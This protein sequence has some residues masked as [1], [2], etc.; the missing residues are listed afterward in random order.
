MCP[1]S[2]P[3]P[4]R[5]M[6][7]CFSPV[8]FFISFLSVSTSLCVCPSLV[9]SLALSLHLPSHLSPHC[10]LSPCALPLFSS[11]CLCASLSISLRL[12][13]HSRL[14]SPSSAV[15]QCLFPQS[16]SVS[17]SP[18]CSLPFLR[19]LSKLAQPWPTGSS[20]AARPLLVPEK[21]RCQSLRQ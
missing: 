1:Q 11:L 4:R 6:P 21:F 9:F 19:S 15:S 10:V 20:V 2:L 17:T 8:L 16:S 18:G 3:R 13:V 5:K 7:L 12:S 14:L